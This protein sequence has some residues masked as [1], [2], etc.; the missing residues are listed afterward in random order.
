VIDLFLS[1]AAAAGLAFAIVG[2]IAA[3]ARLL[4]LVRIG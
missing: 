2:S 4:I 1:L 3:L